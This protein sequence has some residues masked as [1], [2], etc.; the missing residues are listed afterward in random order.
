MKKKNLLEP[1]CGTVGDG[2]GEHAHKWETYTK[3]EPFER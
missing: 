1:W 3:E 2:P